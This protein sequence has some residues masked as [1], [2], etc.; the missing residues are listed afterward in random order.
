[1]LD[2]FLTEIRVLVS[3]SER[4]WVEGD[5]E[6]EG[7]WVETKP[8]EYYTQ[9]ILAKRPETKSQSDLDR[10]IGLGKPQAVIDTF[11]DM[12]NLGIAWDYCDA[13]I[14]WLND[15]D[16]WE[17][18]ETVITYD[19]DEVEISRT[20]KPDEPTEP[21]RQPNYISDYDHVV[22]KREREIAVAAITVEVDGLVYDGDELSQ[23]RMVRAITALT[24]D[25]KMHWT[26]ADNTIVQVTQTELK[27]AIRLAGDIQSS[28]WI[29]P[30]TL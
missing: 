14:C 10:V 27:K 24:G 23:N 15:V 19:E 7:E 28:L 13:Y 26:L 5:V 29:K 6:G 25:E 2:E 4:E 22:F 21:V 11:T 18:W 8:A 17:K 20:E 16:T 30:S 3:P 9:T 1:M 12:V